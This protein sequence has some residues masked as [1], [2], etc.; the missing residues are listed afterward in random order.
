[1][2]YLP[3]HLFAQT[4][5]THPHITTIASSELHKLNF[6]LFRVIMIT[7]NSQSGELHLRETMKTL[8]GGESHIVVTV[9]ETP[10]TDEVQENIPVP[11]GRGGKGI[12]R[13][14]SVCDY[15]E[16]Y[17]C[18]TGEHD[19]ATYGFRCLCFEREL[20]SMRR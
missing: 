15:N 14:I 8:N 10:A 19:H 4:I 6:I 18:P 17:L 11:D 12:V 16:R 9:K 1:M 20:I 3:F 5:F 2:T 7:L 13:C